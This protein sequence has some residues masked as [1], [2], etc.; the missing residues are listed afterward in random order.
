MG[1]QSGEHAVKSPRQGSMVVPIL[2]AFVTKIMFHLVPAF[3]K[4][5]PKLELKRCVHPWVSNNRPEFLLE[6]LRQPEDH[7]D[8]CWFEFRVGMYIDCFFQKEGFKF[9]FQV[10]E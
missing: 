7:I 2:W 6:F 5:S 4:N 8:T 9:F 3:R 1:L 10:F